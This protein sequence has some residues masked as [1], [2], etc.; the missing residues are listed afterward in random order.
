MAAL[1]RDVG[2]RVHR[3]ILVLLRGRAPRGRE[4]R[5]CV[6]LAL[7]EERGALNAEDPL[8]LVQAEIVAGVRGIFGEPLTRPSGAPSAR[9]GRRAEP[10]R[11]RPRSAPQSP[12][13]AP[14]GASP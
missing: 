12:G 9:G 4:E 14:G 6:A 8:T 3:G 11:T 7:A 10:A 13:A 5:R 1:S 2:G